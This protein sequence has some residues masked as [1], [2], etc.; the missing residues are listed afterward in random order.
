[1]CISLHL[2]KWPGDKMMMWK[3]V[4]KQIQPRIIL[5]YPWKK[6]FFMSNW[7]FCDDYTVTAA[8]QE[9][10]SR[11]LTTPSF[12]PVLAFFWPEEFKPVWKISTGFKKFKPKK[13]LNHNIIILYLCQ[14]I[15]NSVKAGFFS[16][17]STTE[18][19]IYAF[20]MSFSLFM[21]VTEN[22]VKE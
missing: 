8:S 15:L 16:P 22:L 18:F 14:G 1:M 9:P 12:T 17:M 11:L 7:H 4:E 13:N 2:W 6:F 19:F 5:N 20:L 3:G 21:K 10:C